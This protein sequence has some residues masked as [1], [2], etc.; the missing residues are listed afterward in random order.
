MVVT[1]NII[2]DK[3]SIVKENIFIGT[4]TSVEEEK[5]NLIKAAYFKPAVDFM[6]LEKVLVI[7]K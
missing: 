6:Q 1:S 5:T 2:T 7:K 3:N 4:V